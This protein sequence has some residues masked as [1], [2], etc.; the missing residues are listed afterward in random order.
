[1]TKGLLLGGIDRLRRTDEVA[2][3]A[4]FNFDK[5]QNITVTADQVDL[6]PC[7]FVIAGEHPVTVAAHESARHALTVGADLRC[8]RQ[9]GRGRTF[10][11][12]ETF[13]DELGKGREG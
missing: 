10:V 13:A 12:V 1:M 7:R 2:P 3:G 9:L 5:N 8:G 6:A 4:G 11:S